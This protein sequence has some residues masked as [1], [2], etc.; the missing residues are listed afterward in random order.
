MA[1][2][3]F[4][5]NGGAEAIPGRKSAHACNVERINVMKLVTAKAGDG[6]Y[7]ESDQDAAERGSDGA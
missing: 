4:W 7:D 5:R 2:L 1:R 6:T 3:G